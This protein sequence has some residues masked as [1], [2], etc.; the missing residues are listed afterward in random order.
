VRKEQTIL[1]FDLGG[2]C[3]TYPCWRSARASSG[4]GYATAAKPPRR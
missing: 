4:E 3:S 2:G 1:V